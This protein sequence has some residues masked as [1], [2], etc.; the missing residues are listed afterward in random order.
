MLG[1]WLVRN[2]CWAYVGELGSWGLLGGYVGAMLSICSDKNVDVTKGTR[3]FWVMGLHWVDVGT[4]LWALPSFTVY[5]CFYSPSS[6][7]LRVLTTFVGVRLGGGWCV[8]LSEVLS[9]RVSPHGCLCSMA[10]PPS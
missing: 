3:R 7:L 5:F 8:R 9:P 6:A 4:Y 10:W 1:L 2:L